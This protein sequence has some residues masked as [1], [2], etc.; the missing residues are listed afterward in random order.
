MNEPPSSY[1][2]TRERGPTV[3][4]AEIERAARAVMAQGLRPTSKAVLE[5]LG[6]G[7]PNHIA[8]S[9]QRFWKDQA[10]LNAG[11]PL[12]LSRLPPELAD[13]AVAQWEQA[14]RLSQ[15]T[16]KYEDSQARVQLEQLRRETDVRVRSVELREKEWDIAARVRE[17]ALTDAREQVNLLMKE[18][19]LD[20][21]ELRARDARIADLENQLEEHRRQLVTVIARAVSKNRAGAMAKPRPTHRAKPKGRAA[22]PRKK[23]SLVKRKP[24]NSKRKG[25]GKRR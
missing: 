14:L 24:L 21:A 12:A 8:E 1:G 20:R 23:R 6:R 19:A 11:D 17:R 16:A 25:H 2:T 3:S 13:A 4:Y 5:H 15:Q 18:L 22:A 9:M 10:A 7:S